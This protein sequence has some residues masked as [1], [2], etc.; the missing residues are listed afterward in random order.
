MI[1]KCIASGSKGN[2]YVL[3]AAN[4]I[5][6]LEAGMPL[7]EVKKAIDYQILKIKGCLVTHE[8]QDHLKYVREYLNAGIP[9]YTNDET[10]ESIEIVVNELLHGIPEKQWFEVGE[11]RVIPFYVP[12]NET[13]CFAYIIEHRE[14]GKLMFATDFEYLPWT[15]HTW[16]INH[17]LIE[18]N[19]DMK[20]V[21]SNIPNYEHK[22]KGHCSLETCMDIIRSNKAPSLRNIIMCHLSGI[23]GLNEY[24]TE[25]MEKTAGFGV[26]VDCAV[27][28]LQVE[29]K[30]DPF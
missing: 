17:F 5:L 8:H 1:L 20:F 19:Y 3:S 10:K 26:K 12:H 22:L 4:E 9:V 29:L 23:S 6:L 15:F 24:F 13:P 2:S 11:F 21:N 27:P 30:K 7:K 14:I 25:A 16:R 18:A 28:G